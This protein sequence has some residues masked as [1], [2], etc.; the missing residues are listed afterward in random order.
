MKI[1]NA[2]AACQSQST[3]LNRYDTT[4]VLQAAILLL[5]SCYIHYWGGGEEVRDRG[6]RDGLYSAGGGGGKA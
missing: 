4:C 1:S 5:H 6:L 2:A 3:L